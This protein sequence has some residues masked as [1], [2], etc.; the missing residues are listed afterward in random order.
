M[1]GGNFSLA[2]QNCGDWHGKF[3]TP[4]CSIHQ[5][6]EQL[7]DADER[8]QRE[9]DQRESARYESPQQYYGHLIGAQISGWKIDERRDAHGEDAKQTHQHNREFNCSR[10]F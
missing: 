5:P 4:S 7:F 9:E 6:G 2:A 3:D 8:F 1:K 10:H